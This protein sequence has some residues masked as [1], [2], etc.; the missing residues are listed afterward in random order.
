[1][2]LCTSAWL[3][4]RSNCKTQF[5]D[6]ISK[7]WSSEASLFACLRQRSHVAKGKP[8]LFSKV[9]QKLAELKIHNGVFCCWHNSWV[10]VSSFWGQE[11]ENPLASSAERVIMVGRPE[12]VDL[13]L[14][15]LFAMRA[16]KVGWCWIL[17]GF[18]L[19]QLSNQEWI[20]SVVF[21]IYCT[22]P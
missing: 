4:E 15:R 8:D 14:R 12:V 16:P 19:Y 21:W 9:R 11:R 18:M 17:N 2:G 5:P 7:D 1:M 13:L 10:C 22:S 3:F 20:K 6:P